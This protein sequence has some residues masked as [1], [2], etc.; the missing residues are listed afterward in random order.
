[1]AS[2]K[3]PRF[4]ER[5]NG[6]FTRNFFAEIFFRFPGYIAHSSSPYPVVQD[7]LTPDR[8]FGTLFTF[9]DQEPCLVSLATV[10]SVGVFNFIGTKHDQERES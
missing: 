8:D 1:M 7:P 4:T 5:V 9:S 10:G 2:K 3:D 6:K